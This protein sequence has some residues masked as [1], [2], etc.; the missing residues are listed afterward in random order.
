MIAGKTAIQGS[1]HRHSAHA[2]QKARADKSLR[3]VSEAITRLLLHKVAKLA[4]LSIKI[5][6]RTDGGTDSHRK[7]HEKNIL[8]LDGTLNAYE[9]GTKANTDHNG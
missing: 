5:Q 3:N 8:R 9:K 7:D 6:Q 1:R 4:D 2:K